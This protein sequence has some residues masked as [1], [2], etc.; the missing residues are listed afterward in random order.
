MGE[1]ERGPIGGGGPLI[2]GLKRLRKV[3]TQNRNTA[4]YNNFFLVVLETE[5]NK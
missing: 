4:S 1:I 3:D 5:I 2:F